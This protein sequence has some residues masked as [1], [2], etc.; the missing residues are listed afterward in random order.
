MQL[1]DLFTIYHLNQKQFNHYLIIA[2]DG[3]VEY[4]YPVGESIVGFDYSNASYYKAIKDGANEFWSPTYVDTKYDEISVDYALPLDD[5][6]LIGTIHLEKLRN[7]LNSII[8][9]EELIVGITDHTGVY[10]LHSNYDYVE[11]RLQ[12]L[13]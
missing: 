3:L 4:S 2:E 10:I 7:I 6:V 12:I 8:N 11:Q 13:C 9:E 1:E 5:K